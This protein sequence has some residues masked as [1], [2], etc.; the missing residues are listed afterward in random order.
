MS[1]VLGRKGHCKAL[2]APRTVPPAGSIETFLLQPRAG[3]VLQPALLA[4][5]LPSCPGAAH[6]RGH[7]SCCGIPPRFAASVLQGPALGC[8]AGKG[9]VDLETTQT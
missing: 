1:L 9:A 2:Y 8:V 5:S 6:G 4:S 3:S 7:P